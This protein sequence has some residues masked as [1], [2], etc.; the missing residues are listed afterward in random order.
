M[1]PIDETGKVYGRLTVLEKFD[2]SKDK[3]RYYYTRPGVFWICRCECGAE[4]LVYG[5]FLRSGQTRSCGCLR[6]EK[7]SKRAKARKGTHWR[8][9]EE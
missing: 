5:G 8:K 3:S 2:K 6:S 7:S 1:K 9:K 4:T